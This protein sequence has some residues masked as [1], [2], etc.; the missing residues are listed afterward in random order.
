MFGQQTYVNKVSIFAQKSFEQLHKII[1]KVQYLQR[2]I[3]ILLVLFVNIV[4]NYIG[5]GAFNKT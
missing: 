1:N 4:N 5:L 2:F 3:S